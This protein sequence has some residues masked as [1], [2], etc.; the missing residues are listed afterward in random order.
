MRKRIALFTLAAAV[1]GTGAAAQTTPDTARALTLSLSQAVALASDTAPAVRL[2]DI[3]TAEAQER[4]RQAQGALLPTVG[5]AA[6]GLEQTRNL[7]TFGLSFPSAL[8]GGTHA[9]VT[10]WKG[11]S[12]NATRQL[13]VV[14]H[15]SAQDH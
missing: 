1:T 2:A 13:A 11:E 15:L 6:A 10:V 4:V 14:R 3:R 8:P 7:K 12:G 5:A 9:L